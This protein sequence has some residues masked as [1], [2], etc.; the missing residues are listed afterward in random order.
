MSITNNGTKVVTGE[1]RFSYVHVFQPHAV[2]DGQDPKYSVTLLIPKSDKK[3]VTNIKRAIDAAKEL[4]AGSKWGG[5]VPNG[6]KMPLRDGDLEREDQEEF[7]GCYFINA[8]SKQK[9][10]VVDSQLQEIIDSTELFSGCYGK[11]SINFYAFAVSGNKGIAAGLNNLQKLRDG[12]YLGGR[13]SAVDDF[14]VEED[15]YLG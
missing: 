8:N 14:N 12:D 13:S 15:D 2:E 1:V 9:P 4:G 6:L 3:T 7:T 10:G 11:A 5:K